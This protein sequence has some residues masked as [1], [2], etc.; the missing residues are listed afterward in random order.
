MRYA[1]DFA[2]RYE[3][4]L[5]EVRQ[6]IQSVMELAVSSAFA[7]STTIPELAKAAIR[8]LEKNVVQ[9]AEARFARAEVAMEE[10]VR[11]NQPPIVF[12]LNDHY[13]DQIFRDLVGQDTISGSTDEGSA[14]ILYYRVRAFLK[15]QTKVIVEAVAKQ[16][17][18]TLKIGMD[19]AFKEAIE[20]I[21][22]SEMI[23]NV[24]E[25]P[26]R[27]EEMKRL[28]ARKDVLE[29]KITKLQRLM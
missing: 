6:E 5:H 24:K 18:L 15:V 12:T 27:A 26:F 2:E 8:K 7:E 19:E 23:G 17:L 1:E 29:R 25:S 4:V 13:L 20:S 21:N 16:L 10:I 22:V 9:L 28:E 14:T 11:W 3:P